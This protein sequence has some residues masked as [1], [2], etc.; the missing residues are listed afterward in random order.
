MWSQILSVL[1]VVGSNVKNVNSIY[2]VGIGCLGVRYFALSHNTC[3]FPDN[4]IFSTNEFVAPQQLFTLDLQL[5]LKTTII[6]SISSIAYI[7]PTQ[8]QRSKA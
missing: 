3:K 7:K 2:S 1:A 8:A 4:S 5:N 6:L